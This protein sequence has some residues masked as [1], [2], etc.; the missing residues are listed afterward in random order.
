MATQRIPLS[1]VPKVYQLG[2]LSNSKNNYSFHEAVEATSGS[3]RD[4]PPVSGVEIEQT[5]DG[6][7]GTSP[8]GGGTVGGPFTSGSNV[9]NGGG[10]GTT[11]G[12]NTTAPVDNSTAPLGPPTSPGGTWSGGGY[13]ASTTSVE[14][15]AVTKNLP[16]KNNKTRNLLLLLAAAGVI[17]YV[18]YANKDK[19]IA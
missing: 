1:G 5:R 18:I 16:V 2:I 14:E 7:S 9:N 19:K 10:G 12:S 11:P 3:T 6:G 17:A 8:V 15:T 4:T 13:V